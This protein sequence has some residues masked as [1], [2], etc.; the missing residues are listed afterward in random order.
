MSQHQ[1]VLNHSVAVFCGGRFCTGHAWQRPSKNG[2]RA[3]IQL[4]ERHYRSNSFFPSLDIKVSKVKTNCVRMNKRLRRFLRHQA[5]LLTN[6]GGSD[7]GFTA[8]RPHWLWC[9]RIR[10]IRARQNAEKER[11]GMR[12][13]AKKRENHGFFFKRGHSWCTRPFRPIRGEI[14][15]VSSS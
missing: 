9:P 7:L 4:V 8:S 10:P 14:R 3:I 13:K 15:F 1:A 6:T 2:R 11:K 5:S 12:L